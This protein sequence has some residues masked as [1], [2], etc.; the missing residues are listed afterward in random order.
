MKA[1]V[2]SR[3][4]KQNM[5]RGF[6]YLQRNGLSA[7]LFKA[8]ERLSR[9]E[10][11]AD[12]ETWLLEHQ[13][14]D[15]MLQEQR[16]TVF[17]NRYKISILVPAY[18]SSPIF[19]RELIESVIRQSYT[20]WELCIADGS[21]SDVVK[22]C[23]MDLIGKHGA[24]IGCN[25]IK[26][27][28]LDKNYGISVNSNKALEMATGDYVGLLDHDDLLTPDALYEVVSVLQ[29]GIC[30][31]GRV[32][33]NTIRAVYS[34]EDKV[35]GTTGR[36][37]DHHI[38]PE[39]NLDLLRTN[40]Y[41][42]HFFVVDS[43]IAKKSGGFRT[44]FNGAQDH[45]FILRCVENAP[46]DSV[47]HIPKV[48]YHWRAHEYS[49]ADHPESKM[50]AYDAGKRAVEAH[51][52]R[53]LINAQVLYTPHLGFFRIKY[54]PLNAEV[55]VMSKS[56]WDVVKMSDLSGIEEEYIMVLN[57]NLHPVTSKWKQELLGLFARD[58]VGAAAG[59]ILDKK[60]RIESAGYSRNEEGK[61]T[62]N[63]KG[64]NRHYSGYMHRANLQQAV[65]GLPLDCMMIRKQALIK[66]K[67]GLAMS[68]EYVAVYDPY[69]VF[70]RK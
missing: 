20:E 5:E 19:L 50:Y 28:K 21:T 15:Q 17:K 29:S 58:D 16:K 4:N 55:A 11:E 25:R 7:A 48:L 63:F 70:K 26:Y 13:P 24:V 37:F 38:K 23:V 41:I 66:S 59:K 22:N 14:D 12:Y 69:A 57:D 34:D 8:S 68:K 30:E 36:H 44:E 62:A 3:F 56:E 45:D 52:E 40:N 27:Q 46:K 67:N 9:D 49:T 60:N 6:R 2:N 33:H 51:L 61:L 47:C 18:E 39:F 42:C 65:D 1:K 35:D 10:A 64:L 32:T 43:A 31:E 53:M 54:A